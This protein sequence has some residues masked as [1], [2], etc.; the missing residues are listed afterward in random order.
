M[1]SAEEIQCATPPQQLAALI[2]PGKAKLRNIKQAKGCQRQD[3]KG[4]MPKAGCQRQDAKG[5]FNAAA[6]I[7]CFAGTLV[8]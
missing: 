5:R 4:R 7:R 6:L 1:K 3:A 8:R 2:Q